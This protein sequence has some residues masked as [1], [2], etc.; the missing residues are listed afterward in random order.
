MS[1]K[2]LALFDFD[3][4]VT[5]KDTLFQFIIFNRGWLVF[6]F[7]FLLLV[8]VM[9]MYKLKL[10]PNWRAKE[11]MLSLFFRSMSIENFQYSCERFSKD[12]I[13]SLVREQAMD[14]IRRIKQL[15]FRVIIVSASPENW[16]RGWADRNGVELIA[17]KLEVKNG[18]ITG[19]I[20]G[21][22][23]YGQEKVNRVKSYLQLDEYDEIFAYGDTSGD[24]PMLRLAHQQYYK[25]FRN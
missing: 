9:V 5:E 4:T 3:G 15:G 7:G 13:D 22:N 24:K 12:K 16:I 2:S 11:L 23:C 6:V 1:K 8:P 25:P 14:E 10:I 18:K 17:T 20:E 19:R 21:K